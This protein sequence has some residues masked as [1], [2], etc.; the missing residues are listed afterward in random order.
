[1]T[2]ADWIPAIS[3]SAVLAAVSFGVGVLFKASV[4]KGIS[5]GLD[6]KLEELKGEIRK[7]E[8]EL[9]AALRRS[10]DRID[11]LRSGPLSGMSAR[12]IAL[13]QRRA[14]AVERVWSDVVGLARY[15]LLSDMTASIKMDV[16]MERG[17]GTGSDAKKIQ[18]FA[19][20]ILESSGFKSM[21]DFK[22]GDLADR[23]R[24]FLDPMCWAL[25]SAY[26][27]ILTMPALHLNLV[28]A[29][30]DKGLL[31]DPEATLEPVRVALPGWEK[32]LDEH[33]LA[34][35]PHLVKPLEDKLLGALTSSL[36]GKEGDA[37]SVR[38]AADILAAVDKAAAKVEEI[39]A[40]AVPTVS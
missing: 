11:A 5:H 6:R 28:K 23:E 3:S 38:R 25:F 35:L 20:M 4:E 16:L 32:F 27:L 17:A 34:A 19:S 7:D 1:M 36:E 39:G 37:E 40:P 31:K 9:K 29:G 12:N 18:E 2:W 15:K 26:R 8:E 33:K 14:L 21:E 24:P 10:D 22:I 13:S 30:L